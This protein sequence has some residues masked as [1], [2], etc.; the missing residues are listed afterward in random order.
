V[1]ELR[2]YQKEGVDFLCRVGRCLLGDDMGLGKTPQTLIACEK[3]RAKRV[4]VVCKKSLCYH[5][6]KQAII[7]W[8]DAFTIVTDGKMEDRLKQ[9]KAW[10][11]DSM[12]HDSPQI[13]VITP[14]FLIW[15][16][17][18]EELVKKGFDVLVVDEAHNFTNRKGKMRNQLLKISKASRRCFLLTGTPVQNQISELWSLANLLFPKK[19]T[20][21]WNFVDDTKGGFAHVGRDRWGHYTVSREASRPDA[22]KE[23]MKPWFLRRE[24]ED[25]QTLPDKVYQILPIKMEGEQDRIYREMESEWISKVGENPEEYLIAGICLTQ[26]TFLKQITVSP[27]LVGGA[28]PSAKLEA[29]VDLIESTDQKVVVMSQ[30]AEAIKLVDSMLS[31][32]KIPHT[33]FTGSLTDAEERFR[34]CEEFNADPNIKVFTT[35]I[36]AG[37]EGIDLTGGSLFIFLDKHWNPAVN[38]QAVSRL[39]RYG[40]KRK[41]TVIEMQ[42]EDSVEQW[43][44]ELLDEKI[45][46]RDQ[47][48]SIVKGRVPKSYEKGIK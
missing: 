13:L 4:L 2:D 46:V 41:V 33:G 28:C 47:V 35:T 34:R 17:A 48:I 42:A 19:Y 12:I 3:S 9:V 30:F 39:H 11:L 5:W 1:P 29:M 44:D 23:E 7:W 6:R 10:P 43:I 8:P 22:L 24:K 16:G 18:T 37:G 31:D 38:E 20:S 15:E 26:I 27:F 25:V 36:K 14:Q 32:S 40:Q 45:D 21:F